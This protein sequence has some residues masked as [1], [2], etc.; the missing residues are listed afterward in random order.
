MLAL[1]VNALAYLPPDS[2]QASLQLKLGEAKYKTEM[3]RNWQAGGCEFGGKCVF[4][5]GI[6]E[7]R[8]RGRYKTKE[9]K[10]FFTLGYCCY[11]ERCQFRHSNSKKRL[12][13]FVDLE[14][15]GDCLSN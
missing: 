4:A 11:G 1:N 13:V 12:P 6:G 15:R 10:Q 5:H 2:A 3:C 7:L 8:V 9:C 14:H